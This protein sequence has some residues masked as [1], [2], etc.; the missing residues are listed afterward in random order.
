M[1]Q[2]LRRH[3]VLLSNTVHSK[4]FKSRGGLSYQSELWS[5]NEANTRRGFEFFHCAR[6]QQHSLKKILTRNTHL[7]TRRV[8][9]AQVLVLRGTCASSSKNR[10]N[11][12][13]TAFLGGL[14]TVIGK[15][16]AEETT[17]AISSRRFVTPEQW[18]HV[19]PASASARNHH[20]VGNVTKEFVVREAGSWQS[21]QELRG[22]NEL[23]AQ[24]NVFM[25]LQDSW[26]HENTSLFKTALTKSL[27]LR[28]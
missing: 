17:R 1:W 13:R 20:Y 26:K 25:Q 12:D 2:Q 16:A 10:L 7:G 18:K 23:H 15:A 8:C 28:S 27:F 21:R 19:F 4:V 3:A 9:A 6:Q 14:A 5:L 11:P 22:V 24:Q